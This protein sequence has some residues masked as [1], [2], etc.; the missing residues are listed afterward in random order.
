[1]NNLIDCFDK[2]LIDANWINDR[3]TKSFYTCKGVKSQGLGW[4]GGGFSVFRVFSV[5]I[6]RV[7]GF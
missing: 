1:M 7:L 3:K 4:R 2:R 5:W 6:F